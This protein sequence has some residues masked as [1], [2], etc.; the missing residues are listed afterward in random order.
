VTK[1]AYAGLFLL[2]FSISAAAAEIDWY[3]DLRAASAKAQESNRPMMI[4][5]WADWCAPCKVM[6][7]EVYPHPQVV[8]ALSEK[9]IAVR[10][11]FD[12]QTDLVRRFKVEAI[13]CIVFTN[14]YG[15]ELLRH[16]GILE[17]EVL[18]AVIEA[19]PADVSE[20]NRLD[21]VL[22]KD[23]NNFE[24][25][26]EMASRLRS[27]GL[28]Q[29]STQF[30]D[31]AIK[32]DKARKSPTLREAIL[33]EIGLNFLDLRDGKQAVAVFERCLKEFPKSE[34]RLRLT[35]ELARARRLLSEP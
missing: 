12:L 19:L 2:I 31:R 35:E 6:E 11:H 24:A 13:P 25:L 27:G 3:K 21:R 32:T 8:A 29:M 33:L 28:Y 9:M 5:F 14:S 4:E 22:Q 18:T 17:V 1:F 10:I 16:R 30:Y 23:R 34:N 15:T 7:A 26:Q 20:L